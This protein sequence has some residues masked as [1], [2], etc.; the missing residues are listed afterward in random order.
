M[1]RLIA[2]SFV[3]LAARKERSP[4]STPML[5]TTSSGTT[6]ISASAP[7]EIVD[8]EEIWAL[9]SAAAKRMRTTTNRR[10]VNL[11]FVIYWRG[12]MTPALIHERGGAEFLQIQVKKGS[13]APP[14][15]GFIGQRGSLS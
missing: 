5:S 1:A 2:A 15:L 3:D 7:T 9:Q 8:G 4:V 13:N 11:A 14:H 6:R 10:I 12:R